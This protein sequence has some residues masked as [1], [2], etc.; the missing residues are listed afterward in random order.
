MSSVPVL[1]SLHLCPSPACTRHFMT[2]RDLAMDPA[3]HNPSAELQVDLAYMVEYL[4]Q[5]WVAV[6]VEEYQEEIAV[7]LQW[8]I[9]RLPWLFSALHPLIQ[10]FLVFTKHSL[11]EDCQPNLLVASRTSPSPPSSKRKRRSCHHRSKT[12]EQT[13]SVGESDC[14]SVSR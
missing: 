6:P 1:V 2:G 7:Q 5:D 3:A 9:S 8:M 10:D 4:C 13:V 11:P 14:A 12:A